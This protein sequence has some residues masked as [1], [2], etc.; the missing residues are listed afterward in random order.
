MQPVAHGGRGGRAAA[1]GSGC[2]RGWQQAC[3]GCRRAA[4]A[5]VQRAQLQLAYSHSKSK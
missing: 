2:S 3:R 4:A 5:G 1:Q